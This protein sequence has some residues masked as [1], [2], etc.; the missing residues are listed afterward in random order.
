MIIPTSNNATTK[1]T[2]FGT[3]EQRGNVTIYPACS[4]EM[5]RTAHGRRIRTAAYTRVSTDSIQQEVSLILQREYFENQIKNNPEYEFAGIYEDDGITATI[6]QTYVKT[7]SLFIGSVTLI[8]EIWSVLDWNK[9]LRFRI[10]AKYNEVPNVAIFELKNAVSA[11][12]LKNT[13][14]RRPIQKNT[15]SQMQAGS[16]EV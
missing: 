6:G 15:V 2:L 8:H 13:H 11:E 4:P 3:P 10:V 14:G 16:T 7:G 1:K 9:T 12:I 5:L